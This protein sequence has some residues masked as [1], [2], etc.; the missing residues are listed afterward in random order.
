[1]EA[2]GLNTEKQNPKDCLDALRV[3]KLRQQQA[4]LRTAAR[5]SGDEATDALSQLQR[6]SEEIDRIQEALPP[7]SHQG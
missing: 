1:M 2:V 7:D 4:K 3:L 5:G 6:V